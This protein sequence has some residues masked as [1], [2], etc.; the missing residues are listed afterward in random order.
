LVGLGW[1]I[2]RL[3]AHFNPDGKGDVAAGALAVVL[4]LIP[5]IGGSILLSFLPLIP[6]VIVSAVLL[7]LCIGYRSLAEH[8][9]AVCIAHWSPGIGPARA[10][11]WA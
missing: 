9:M 3:E 7:W 6:W 5:F 2:D 1:C 10:S 8:G 11:V 4:L